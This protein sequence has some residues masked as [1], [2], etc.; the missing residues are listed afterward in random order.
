M[1]L[2]ESCIA[3]WV[4]YEKLDP[5]LPLIRHSSHGEP[6]YTFEDYEN[7]KAELTRWS[8][9]WSN[10]KG[11]NPDKYQADIGAARRKVREIEHYLKETGILER[12]EKEKLEKELDRLFPNTPSKKIVEYNG[13]KYQRRYLPLEKSR[14]RKTVKEWSKRWV[15]VE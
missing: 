3:L 9:L 8:E 6:M 14:S 5:H 11:N 7:A 13:I 15:L 1:G 12:N 4:T 10:Y 2:I